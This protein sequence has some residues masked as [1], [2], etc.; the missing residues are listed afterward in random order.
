MTYILW[1]SDF[2]LC[3]EYYLM[4]EHMGHIILGIMSQCG[5]IF[6]LKIFVGH[7]DL[8]F[9][10]HSFALYLEDCLIYE[11]HTL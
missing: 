5:L 2:A 11:C 6:D 10:V 8:Y 3:L 7:C 1:S 4:Y 9:M